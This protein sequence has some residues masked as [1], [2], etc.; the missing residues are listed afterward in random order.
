M[1]L[2]LGGVIE[3]T[4]LMIGSLGYHYIQGLSWIDGTLNS[5]M[6]ITGNGPAFPP[7]TGAGKIFQIIFS[8]IGVIGFIMILSVILSPVFHRILHSFHIAPDQARG[9]LKKRSDVP[10]DSPPNTSA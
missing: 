7:H 2:I 5:A 4:V 1:F 10:S 8:L 3:T 6:V 9:E